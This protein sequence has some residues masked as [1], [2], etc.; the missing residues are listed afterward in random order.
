VIVPAQNESTNSTAVPALPRR[1]KGMR[2]H[3]KIQRAKSQT[4]WRSDG[5]RIVDKLPV[6]TVPISKFP[7][8]WR[9]ERLLPTAPSR[10]SDLSWSSVYCCS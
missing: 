10:L 5:T 7:V 3:G 2:V 6:G 8:F 4:F 9:V 1:N